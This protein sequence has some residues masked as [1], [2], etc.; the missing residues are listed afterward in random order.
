[1]K[2]ANIALMCLLVLLLGG[3]AEIPQTKTRVHKSIFARITVYWAQGKGSDHWTRQH[4]SATGVKL[5]N[6]NCAVDSKKIPYGSQIVYPDTSIDV[7][8]D[9]GTD[10]INRKAARKAGR[11]IYEKT[12]IVIDKFFETK[13][14]ALKWAACHPLF[15]P[16]QIIPPLNAEPEMNEGGQW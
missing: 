5:H 12:A 3:C 15:L 13:K 11:T 4:R 9:T 6:G 7:A 14:E 16:I 8:T 1:M 2:Y 10:V